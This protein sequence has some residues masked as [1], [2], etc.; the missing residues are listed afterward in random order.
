MTGGEALSIHAKVCERGFEVNIGSFVQSQGST[1]LDSNLLFIVLTGILA[2][3]DP[4]AAGTV[5]AI[6][7]RLMRDGLLMRQD[8]E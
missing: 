6:Q 2:P 8:A 7:P 3:D 1:A 5:R 4:R